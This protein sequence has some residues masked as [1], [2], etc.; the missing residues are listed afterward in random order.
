[1]EDAEK[2]SG[3]AKP[4]TL[5]Y[6]ERAALAYLGKYASSA[7]NLRRVLKRKAEKRCRMQETEPSDFTEMIDQVVVKALRIGLINDQVYADAKTASLRRRGASS[8]F[9]QAKLAEKGLDREKIA[10]ALATTEEPEAEREAARRLCRR[11]KLGPFRQEARRERRDKDIAVLL[12]AG[13]A[14][15]L[16]KSVIDEDGEEADGANRLF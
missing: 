7:E 13:F 5:A 11:R 6:L 3:E 14:F 2:K 12:R 10:Q 15:T 4:V 9:I 8:R 16:A 1:M